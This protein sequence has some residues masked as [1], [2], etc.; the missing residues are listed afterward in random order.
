MNTSQLKE[1]TLLAEAAYAKFLPSNYKNDGATRARLS[2]ID[3]TPNGTFSLRQADLFTDR[4]TLL[5]QSTENTL[6]GFSPGRA[7]EFTLSAA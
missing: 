4:Y 3:F 5:H 7:D 2:D 1:F 6:D